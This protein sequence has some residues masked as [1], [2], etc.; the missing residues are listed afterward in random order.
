M[1]AQRPSHLSSPR[2][3]G[4][5]GR[6]WGRTSGVVLAALVLVIVAACTTAPSA[7]PSA[8]PSSSV[9]GSRPSSP[10]VVTIVQPT[11]NQVVTGSTVHVVIA[12]QNATIVPATTTNIRP[13]QGH[14]HL[15]VDNVLVSMN[16]GLTQ[17]LPVHPGTYVLKAEFVAADHAPFDPRVISQQIA[18]TV[19]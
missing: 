4:R 10:A 18:F 1:P 12:L 14:V 2:P 6:A 7:S 11:P 13:D 17:D 19:N 9:T 3:S 16:Y 8:A 15:Y 5:T